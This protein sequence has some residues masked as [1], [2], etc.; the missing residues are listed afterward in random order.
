MSTEPDYNFNETSSANSSSQGV[1]VLLPFSLLSVALAV[2]MVGQTINTFKARTALR[3]GKAQ[4]ADMYRNREPVVKQSAEIQKKLQDLILDLL[5]L[6][7]TDPEAKA[8]V[9][10]FQIQQ[11]GPASGAETPAPAPAPAP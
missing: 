6:S 8:I 9:D 4:L 3:E 7:K 2:V 5:L 1:S 10:K 11:Q